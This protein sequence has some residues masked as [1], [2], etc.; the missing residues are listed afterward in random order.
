[1]KTNWALLHHYLHFGR[2]T[3]QKNGIEEDGAKLTLNS[4]HQTD[5]VRS[6]LT[7]FGKTKEWKAGHQLFKTQWMTGTQ[8][9]SIGHQTMYVG[10]TMARK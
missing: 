4:C 1:M 9:S 5:G 3:V 7:S 6:I 10:Y 2:V 8:L